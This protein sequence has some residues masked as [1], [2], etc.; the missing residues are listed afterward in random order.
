MRLRYSVLFSLLLLLCA[1]AGVHA[2]PITFQLSG[3]TA[4]KQILFESKAPLEYIEGKAD[5]LEGSVTID[6]STPRLGLRGTVIVPVESMQTGNAQRDDHLRS[7]DWLNAASF[8]AI[9][10][11]LDSSAVAEATKKGPGKWFVNAVGQF[12]M[13]GISK[14]ISVPV[15]ITF[16]ENGTKNKLTV[17]GRFS[18]K[19]SD[20]GIHGPR[21]IRMIGARVNDVVSVSFRMVGEEQRGVR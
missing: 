8:P 1:P 14:R 7:A 12:Y 4:K 19:L 13:K 5:Q 9:R 21:A 16:K 15:T 20:Y 3:R 11:D 18:L 2:N 6:P 10:F 17:E